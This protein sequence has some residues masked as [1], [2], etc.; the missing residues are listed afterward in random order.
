MVMSVAAAQSAYYWPY[1]KCT[2]E[3]ELCE[4]THF[5]TGLH[6]VCGGRGERLREW[7]PMILFPLLLDMKGVPYVRASFRTATSSGF[8]TL[9]R[10]E[11]EF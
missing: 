11:F 7:H 10:L 3:S 8:Q 9:S 2:R 1:L 5:M 6:A 4:M